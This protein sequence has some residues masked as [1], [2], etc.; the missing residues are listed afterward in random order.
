MNVKP[1]SC[2]HDQPNQPFS[3]LS[4]CVKL[5]ES[6]VRLPPTPPDFHDG[7]SKEEDDELIRSG[8]H[9]ILTERD[10]L[11]NLY[12]LY[13]SDPVARLSFTQAVSALSKSS[14]RGGRVIV[15][16][17]GKSGKIGQKSVATLNSFGIRSAFLHP[18]EALH[19]DLGMIGS[20]DTIVILTYSGR[21]PEILSLLPFLPPDVPL[22]AITSYSDASSCP[23]FTHRPPSSCILLPAPVPRSEVEV[24]GVPA[25]TSSTA[26]ALALTD[27]LALAVA[28]R[29]HSNPTT[30]FH[31]YHPGGA[32]GAKA[33]QTTP[34]LMGAIAI[35]VEDVPVMT[36]WPAR[37]PPTILDVILTA[38]RSTSGWVRPTPESIIAPRQIQRIGRILDV[39]NP[40]CSLTDSIMV[41]K[42]DWISIPAANSVQE[43]RDWVVRMRQ[44]ERGKTFL[45]KGTVLGIVDAQQSVSGVV[46]IE[47]V[48]G[49]DELED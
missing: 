14:L 39:G 27:A 2:W 10:A 38:A 31:R 41:E 17:V 20:Q 22:V 18:T 45:K 26:T 46:E 3:P 28:R 29:L 8:L 7:F 9:V 32:I 30:V 47:D 44:T 13:V 4:P 23:L 15:C 34:E 19:G 40:I 36:P 35:Q 42:G 37:G 5:Q 25:P 43:A 48:V 49:E 6:M 11:T 1:T 12:E 21:T 16:G 33:A 24:L